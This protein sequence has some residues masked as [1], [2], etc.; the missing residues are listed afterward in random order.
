MISGRIKSCLGL[1][2]IDHAYDYAKHFL[3]IKC[4]FLLYRNCRKNPDAD[5]A[6]VPADAND[7]TPSVDAPPDAATA[8]TV[9]DDAPP[10]AKRGRGRPKKTPAAATATAADN[11]DGV[12]NP[13]PRKRGRGR[14]KKNPPPP[15]PPTP[16]EY[17]TATMDVGDETVTVPHEPFPLH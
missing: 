14:P 10:V 2:W 12:G 11:N 6:D 5:T 8:T 9:T 13:S 7:N 15:P 4:P 1:L 16:P 17:T 3:L